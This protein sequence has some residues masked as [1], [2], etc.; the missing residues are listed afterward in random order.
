MGPRK[1]GVTSKAMATKNNKQKAIINFMLILYFITLLVLAVYSHLLI[2]PN[3]WYGGISV[4]IMALIILSLTICYLYFLKH[5][6][7]RLFLIIIFS[8]I[9]TFAGH[10]AA[11]SRDVYNYAM[12]AKTLVVYHQN[13][14]VT[15]PKAFPND[16]LL[17]NIHWPN[18]P[19]RYGP[20]WIL[21]TSFLYYLWPSLYSFKLL[22]VF[23][24]LACFYLVKKL[25]GDLV[26]LVFNPLIIIEYFLGTHTDILMTMFILLALYKN[27]WAYAL[28]S[29]LVKI[30]SLPVAVFYWIKNPRILTWL[31]YL[32]TFI[33]IAKWSIN[34]WYFT[35][36]LVLTALI[37][38]S[39]FHKNLAISFSIAAVVR[40]LPLI[41]LGPF[42][43]NNKIRAILFCITFLVFWRK[44]VS[45]SI[46]KLES[47]KE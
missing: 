29:I 6:P 20:V 14:W 44:Y 38:K 19:S 4:S 37:T 32:G 15:P 47:G 40:Y 7:K 27:S 1:Y 36:P 35:L 8:I 5:P 26:F 17:K 9:I 16:P 3:P 31:A 13:P 2:D 22:T 33:I 23:S 12:Y 30:T 28:L 39:K 42:D 41:Y 25:K 43:P 34:A 21:P 11:F 24:L 45:Q 18:D 46:Q 10:P